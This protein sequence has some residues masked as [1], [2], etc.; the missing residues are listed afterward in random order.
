MNKHLMIISLVMLFSFWGEIVS[1]ICRCT[2]RRE[3]N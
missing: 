1:L 2:D 3:E